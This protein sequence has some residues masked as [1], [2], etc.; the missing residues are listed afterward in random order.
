M[1]FLDIFKTNSNE[2]K[3]AGWISIAMLLLNWKNGV[4]APLRGR[5]LPPQIILVYWF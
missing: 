4:G 2:I 5:I 1:I 3:K